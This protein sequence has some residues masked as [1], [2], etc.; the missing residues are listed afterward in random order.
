MSTRP[1]AAAAPKAASNRPP[2]AGPSAREMLKPSEFSAT[3]FVSA[4]GPT[5]SPANDWRTG[6]SAATEMARPPAAS[7]PSTTSGVMRVG[8]T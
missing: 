2:A 5:I 8:S 6:A 3:A 7:M 4:P 1:A